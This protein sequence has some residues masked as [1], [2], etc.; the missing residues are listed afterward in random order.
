MTD[1]VQEVLD[2]KAVEA[3]MLE[4][5]TALEGYIEKSNKEI[6]EAKTAS[7][8]TKGAID[9]LSEKAIELG[10]RLADMEQK[11][12]DRY[13]ASA[14][15]KSV[16]EQLVESDEF[17][18]MMAHKGGRARVELK[19]A[20]TNAPALGMAQPMVAGD[21]LNRVWHEPNRMLRIRDVLPVGR[22]TSNVVWFPKEDT[23]TNNAAVVRNTSASP[24]V[25]AEN[26]TKPESALTFT[27]DSEEVVTIA[28]FIPVSKQAL[29]D[30]D[31]LS[32]YVNSR[33]MYGLK[34]TEDAQL[35]NGTGVTGYISGID[36]NSTAYAQADSPHSYDD[37]V[38]YLR[39]AV[40]QLQQSNYMP[41]AMIMNPKDW[42]DLELKREASNGQFIWAD[43]V[44]MAAPRFWGMDV[45][46]SNTCSAGSAYVLD[47]SVYQIFDR[48]D[49]AVEISYEDSTNFQKN[50]ATIRAEERLAFVSYSTSGC[51]K[52]TL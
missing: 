15:E 35:L 10:D 14:E 4:T 25:A 3:Q 17:K 20:I 32:S 27:S 2:I 44:R 18:A 1:K 8:E 33:L 31:F 49:A 24:I 39:D 43:P 40:R 46:V 23:F 9:K 26:V 12:A 45:V 22:T 42:A 52:V 13:E 30:S 51:V 5:H 29:D 19:T 36:T 37:S 6:E 21:R 34:L 50:M 7:A 28:H 48:E 16:G 38:E 41:S 47:P 11:Q